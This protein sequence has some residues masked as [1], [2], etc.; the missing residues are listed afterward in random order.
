MSLNRLYVRVYVFMFACVSACMCVYVR[1]C[2][3]VYPVSVLCRVEPFGSI[4][5]SLLHL[6]SSTASKK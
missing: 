2:A 5:A 4:L 3:C 1:A 6:L